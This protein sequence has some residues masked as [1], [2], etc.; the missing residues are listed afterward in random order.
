[1]DYRYDLEF[2]QVQYKGVALPKEDPELNTVRIVDPAS[3]QVLATAINNEGTSHPYAIRRDNFWYFADSPFSFVQEG[4]RYL[5]FCDLLHDI[6]GVD[7]PPS[8]RANAPGAS[9]REVKRMLQTQP[10]RNVFGAPALGH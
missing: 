9:K 1:V 4:S 10:R 2:R 7:H 3:V 8:S 5:V 6:L